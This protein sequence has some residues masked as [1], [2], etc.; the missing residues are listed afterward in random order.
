[1]ENDNRPVK[2]FAGLYRSGYEGYL[3]FWCD[4]YGGEPAAKAAEIAALER[5]HQNSPGIAERTS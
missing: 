4:F 1:M 2:W 5:T 3:R